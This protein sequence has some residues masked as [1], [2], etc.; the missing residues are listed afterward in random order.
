MAAAK[1]QSTNFARIT[2]LVFDVIPDLFQDLLIARLAPSGLAHALTNQKDQVF[3]LL[4]GQQ[5]KILYPQGGLFQ[6][7]VKD[8]DTSLLFNLLRNLGNIPPHQNG[9]GKVPDKADRSLSANIDRL[10]MQR[11]EV[12]H[13]PNASLSDGEFQARWDI[14]RQSVEEIQNSELNTG[15]FVVAVDTTFTMRMDPSTEKNFITLTAQIED[16]SEESM[17]AKKLRYENGMQKKIKTQTIKLTFIGHAGAGKTCLMRQL[18]R[19]HIKKDV[20]DPTN[21]AELLTKRLQYHLKSKERKKI[22]RGKD[23]ELC[24]IRMRRLQKNYRDDNITVNP[25]L[26]EDS[27][28]SG[29]DPKLSALIG[30]R[31]DPEMERTEESQYRITEEAI[32]KDQKEDIDNIMKE[33]DSLDDSSMAY[34]TLF[35]FGGDK[36][37]HN[38]HHCIMSANSIY[39]LVFDVSEWEKPEKQ[40]SIT[41]EIV[42]WLNSVATYAKDESAKKKGVPPVILVGS[43]MD[44]VTTDE[45]NIL[46]KI[47]EKLDKY[48]VIK[49]IR[50]DHVVE[51]IFIRELNNSD[52]NKDKYEELWSLIEESVDGQACWHDEIPGSWLALE[53][54]IMLNKEQGKKFMKLE[55]IINLNKQL[56]V[57]LGE[58]ELV[59]FLRYMHHAASIF[60]FEIMGKEDSERLNEEDKQIN[61]ILDPNWIVKAFALIITDEKF[62]KKRGVTLQKWK[63]FR[64]IGKLTVELLKLC[65]A[66]F[67]NPDERRVL[68]SVMEH[69][70]LITEQ[71]LAD[72][73]YSQTVPEPYIVP[74]LLEEAKH[75]SIKSVLDPE[76]IRS[77]R[78]LCIV[79]ENPFVPQAIWDKTISAC[80]GKFS[81]CFY[82]AG[83]KRTTFEPQRGLVCGKL[84]K[85]WDFVLHCKGATLKLTMFNDVSHDV[86]QG[87]GQGLRLSIEDIINNILSMNNQKHRKYSHFL[88]ND[89]WVSD[90]ELDIK[91]ADKDSLMHHGH[92]EVSNETGDIRTKLTKDDCL[93]WFRDTDKV[94]TAQ[95]FSDIAKVKKIHVDMVQSLSSWIY[96][97]P[98][99][100]WENFQNQMTMH[101]GYDKVYG[102]KENSI[103]KICQCLMDR[104][105]IGYGEYTVLR[106]AF[107]DIGR[108]QA[109]KVIDEA[110]IEM[111]SL[112]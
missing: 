30:Q 36:V 102:E 55:E 111:E 106:A 28:T 14:I 58:D 29:R 101:L 67:C 2:R 1:Y 87:I 105:D 73:Q 50:D 90:N 18:L 19:K 21:A 52:K 10:R 34:V 112:R 25:P 4:N 100:K 46:D 35:D 54:K 97:G 74:C 7:S 61:A 41:D 33:G 77:S 95:R 24:R 85:I 91:K 9:W 89:Y 48:Q 32:T 103:F 59:P 96:P 108:G 27:N 16:E 6:G 99:G 31:D 44:K 65:W 53:E 66:D 3:P 76:Y 20:R 56:L 82:Q 42:H 69:L 70:G 80:I 23:A 17:V 11:N 57:Q 81:P 86:Q 75:D 104:H 107:I 94:L 12:V 63:S 93:V 88:H 110:L 47:Y 22:G 83:S 26:N 71:K 84:N 72:P 78:T 68:S 38:S 49:D 62:V 8:L 40:E 60:C 45:E 37:F 13:A 39:L 98:G 109:A 15:R 64:K 51:C 43:H 5:K 79:F 92:F